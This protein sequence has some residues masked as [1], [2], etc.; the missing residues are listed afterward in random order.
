MCMQQHSV[1]IVG[2]VLSG[3]F[4]ELNNYYKYSTEWFHKQIQAYYG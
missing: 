4:R 2:T 3:L 1:S